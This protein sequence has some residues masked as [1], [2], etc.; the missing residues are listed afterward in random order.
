MIWFMLLIFYG[1][2]GIVEV[3]MNSKQECID[4]GHSIESQNKFIIKEV[5]CVGRKPTEEKNHG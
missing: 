4:F 2:A 3:Q 1:H 5:Y